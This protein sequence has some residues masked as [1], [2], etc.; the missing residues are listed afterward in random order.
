V[1]T[2]YP[3]TLTA[4]T[5]YNWGA[6]SDINGATTQADILGIFGREGLDL[7][8]RWTTPDPTTPVYKAIKLYRNYDGQKSAFGDVGVLDTVPNPDNLSSFGAV[9]SSDG[10]LT[11]ML[12]SKVLSGT[13]PVTVNLANFTGSG[14][15]Q[16]WQLTSANAITRLADVG[17]SGSTISV[18]LPKQSITLLVLLPASSKPAPPVAVLAASPLAGTAPLAV[19]FNGGGSS[20]PSAAITSYG[21]NFGDGSTAS[22]VTASHTYATAGSY[23][24]TLTVTDSIGGTASASV[25]ITVSAA[26]PAAP[27][28]LIASASGRIVT[29]N[30]QNNSSDQA[31]LYIERAPASTGNYSRVGQVGAGVS[32]FSQKVSRGTYLYRVQAFGSS[33]AVSAYSNFVKIKV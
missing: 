16:V 5:E 7:A 3:G 21:W 8:T 33:G 26:A 13:T 29:L 24:A 9:R 15:A 2:Y 17:Y 1:S 23:T 31:G 18:T 10:A 22:G 20:D 27:S 11:I 12:I 4:I 28:A 6:E 32:T 25:S 19:S 30:W 14:Q